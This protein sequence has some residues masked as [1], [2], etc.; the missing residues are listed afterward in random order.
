MGYEVKIGTYYPF[1]LGS[2]LGCRKYLDI[3]TLNNTVRILCDSHFCSY[4]IRVLMRLSSSTHH[5][6]KYS[7]NV[8]LWG[9]HHSYQRTCAVAEEV[10]T[11]Q[12][13]THVVIGMGGQ[14]LSHNILPKLL[15]PSWDVVVD[16]Q[17]YGYSRFTAN[18]TSLVFEFVRDSDGQVHDSFLL[19]R[20]T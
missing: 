12:G 4:M 10:C 17:H 20:S 8:A 18:A 7:V 2:T 19:K 15:K 14:G 11:S 9:H 13:V 3:S 16:D 6:Q 5:S 1:K